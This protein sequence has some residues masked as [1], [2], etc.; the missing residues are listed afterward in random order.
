MNT[1]L[2]RVGEPAPRDLELRCRGWEQEGALRCLMNT[3]D[4]EVAE[5]S[6]R[7]VV[8]GG[9]TMFGQ[10]TAASWFYIGTQGI[11]GFTHETFVAVA[12]RHF[13]GSLAG[14]RV[15]TAGLGGMGGAQGLAIANLGG[16][17]LIVE[18]D[19]E[20]A[21]RRARDGWVDVVTDDYAQALSELEHGG[22]GRAIALVANIA[23]IAPR[24]VDDGVTF[25]V[26]TDQTAAHDPLHGYVPAGWTPAQAR[27]AAS[28]GEPAH[29]AAVRGS[30]AAH[31]RA[32][33]ALRDRGTVVFEY[34]N[35]PRT[36]RWT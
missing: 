36:R 24:L 11:L 29:A 18:V 32:L 28:S 13:G 30:L 31:A 25:D 4:P 5:D 27:A 22:D 8:Y 6:A 34:G 10:M 26:A 33:L 17:A 7:L 20:R 1:D 9:L 23:E 3:L 16:R 12:R 15:L 21:A 19:P 2:R 35:G 14:R